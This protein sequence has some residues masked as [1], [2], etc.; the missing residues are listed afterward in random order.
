V[1]CHFYKTVERGVRRKEGGREGG[2]EGKRGGNGRSEE[3]GE[4]GKDGGGQTLCVRH[5]NFI[6]N[7][8]SPLGPSQRPLATSA[9][10]QVPFLLVNATAWQLPELQE[11]EDAL[12]LAS[13]GELKQ[14]PNGRGGGSLPLNHS[15]H[16]SLLV[17][18]R[19]YVLSG[20]ANWRRN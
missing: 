2:S 18:T 6:N 9:L 10:A 12:N 1:T 17:E 19:W 4:G 7:V 15:S 14:R 5:R 13:E 3:R 11:L 16:S 20:V 8:S